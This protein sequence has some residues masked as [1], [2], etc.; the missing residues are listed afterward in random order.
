MPRKIRELEADLVRAGFR[1]LP[2]RGKG[3]H[4]RY[5]HPGAPGVPVT[6][7]GAG[8]HDAQAYQEQDARAALAKVRAVLEERR[9]QP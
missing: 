4:R 3:S 2:K 9:R 1:L 5:A 6:I 8:G 7:A